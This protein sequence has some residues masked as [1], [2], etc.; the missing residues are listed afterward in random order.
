MPPY[1][2]TSITGVFILV[3]LILPLAML[4][5][6]AY[7]T[8]LIDRKNWFK[9][10]RV[11]ESERGFWIFGLAVSRDFV[12]LAVFRYSLMIWERPNQ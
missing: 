4:I 5:S 8:G 9:L 3:F 1:L 11:D 7:H 6:Y 12:A 10:Q 2:E